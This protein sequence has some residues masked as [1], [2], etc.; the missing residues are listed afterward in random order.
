MNWDA[1]GAVGEI[2]GAIAVVITL[3]Y[4]VVQ[5]RQNT[6]GIHAAT[7]QTNVSDFNS[8]NIHLATNPKLAEVFDKAVDAPESLNKEEEYS[9]LWLMRSYMNLYQNLYDQTK[10]RRWSSP[11]ITRS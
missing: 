7:I 2:V 11:R 4:L 10:V 3:G 1:V 8:L 6:R 5:V 9:F